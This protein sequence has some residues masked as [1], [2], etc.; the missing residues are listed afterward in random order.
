MGHLTHAEYKRLSIIV[1]SLFLEP[2]QEQQLLNMLNSNEVADYNTG[3][4]IVKSFLIRINSEGLNECQTKAFKELMDFLIYEQKDVNGYVLKGYAGTGK[5]FLISRVISTYNALFPGHKIIVTAP[6]NKAVAVLEENRI[7]TYYDNY[8][9]DTSINYMTIHR[10]LGIK[11][12][13]DNDGEV[14]FISTTNFDSIDAKIIIVDEVSML[15]D[16]LFYMLKDLH[17]KVIYM[18]D[19]LQIPPVN[20]LDSIPL[21]YP[22]KHGLKVLELNQIMRQRGDNP[23]LDKSIELRK[24]IDKKYPVGKISKLNND[25]E[26]IVYIPKDKVVEYVGRILNRYFLCDEYKDNMNHMKIIA[27]TNA[28]VTY[29]NKLVRK[30]LFK[31]SNA[32]FNVGERV[33]ANDRLLTHDF[34]PNCYTSEEMTIQSVVV[35]E[36]DFKTKHFSLDRLRYYIMVARNN[37]GHIKTLKVIYDDDK[38]KY[39]KCLKNIKNICKERSDKDLWREYYDLASASDDITYCYAITCHRS[40]GS[41][42]NNVLVIESDID[43]NDNIIERNRIK[44]TAYTRAKQHLFVL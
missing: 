4:G 26:G 35:D 44:Y 2:E 30:I 39:K 24:N 21:L 27:W 14:S 5:T 22:A 20:M 38:E 6:T 28:M 41:T 17:R 40:Q 34:N 23:L 43:N 18:G 29:Y 13:V 8:E 12:V 16:Q 11:E 10:M 32:K 15:N 25:L 42:Y 7:P 19:P 3:F 9:D 37:Y 33:T 1:G 36:L 31:D